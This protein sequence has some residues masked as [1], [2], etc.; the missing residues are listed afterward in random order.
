MSIAAHLRIAVLV[1]AS[2]IAA[3]SEAGM[4]VRNTSALDDILGDANC[5]G[6]VDPVD[7]LA[8]LRGEAGLAAPPCVDLADVQCDGDVDTIDALQILRFNAGLSVVQESGCPSI[9]ETV[10]PPPSSFDLIDQ[11]VLDGSIDDETGL[12][13]KVYTVFGDDRLP[14]QY[15]GDDSGGPKDSFII[16]DVQSQFDTLS[17]EAQAILRPFLIP[18]IYMGSWASPQGSQ[19]AGLT[20]AGDPA[21]RR[22]LARSVL[23]GMAFALRANAEQI[24]AVTGAPAEG[25]RIAG[26]AS[27]S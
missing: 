4:S 14:G 22:H 25:A 2:L 21:R 6:A 1:V 15:K 9:G 26:G 19:L 3:G 5:S 23:E 12:I 16:T 11:A 8:I 17:P 7:A 18:P 24:E 13:Y 20:S 27:R 10:G